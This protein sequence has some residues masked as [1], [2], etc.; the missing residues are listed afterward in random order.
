M[1]ATGSACRWWKIGTPQLNL[2]GLMQRHITQRDGEDAAAEAKSILEDNTQEETVTVTALGDFSVISGDTVVV[3]QEDTKLQGIFWVDADVHTFADGLHKIQLT[4]NL[5][6]VGYEA[7]AGSNLDGR[8]HARDPYTGILREMRTQSRA[9]APEGMCLGVVKAIGSGVLQ[10]QTD[11]G[12]QLDT[13]DLWIN[14]LYAYDNEEE[15]TLEAPTSGE[16]QLEVNQVI[17]SMT[18]YDVPGKLTGTVRVKTRRLQAAT[19]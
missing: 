10:V 18:L 7:D 11:T 8:V 17:N 15:L 5:K 19:G 14:P 2:Y 13:E 9:S 16:A 1:T 3:R 4:L 6:N 12:L